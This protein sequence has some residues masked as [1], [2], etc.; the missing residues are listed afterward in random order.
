MQPTR[1]LD[2]VAHPV[3]STYSMTDLNMSSANYSLASGGVELLISIDSALDG[4]YTGH[5]SSNFVVLQS[6]DSTAF[7]IH[8][9]GKLDAIKYR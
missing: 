8:P 6:V 7:N 5:K 1:S 2:V 3:S 4:V 9:V